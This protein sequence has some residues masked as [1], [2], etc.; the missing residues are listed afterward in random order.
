MKKARA[1]E[2]RRKPQQKAIE[3]ARDAALHGGRLSD[4]PYKDCRWQSVWLKEFF[5]VQQRDLF[6]NEGGGRCYLTK[7]AK[8]DLRV[9]QHP[10][11]MNTKS[12]SG[13]RFH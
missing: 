6:S 12:V 9:A 1:A 8:T 2:Q 5:A 4:C 11:A 10:V 3:N 13:T 7:F